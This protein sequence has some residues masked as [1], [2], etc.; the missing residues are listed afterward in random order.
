MYREARAAEFVP[1]APEKRRAPPLIDVDALN[2]KSASVG[3]APADDDAEPNND[4]DAAS[5]SP[6]AGSTPAVTGD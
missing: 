1:D 6:D 4:G 3:D 5:G 2:P